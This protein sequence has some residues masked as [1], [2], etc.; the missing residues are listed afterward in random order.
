MKQVCK[1]IA[2]LLCAALLTAF[3]LPV[4]AEEEAPKLPSGKTLEEVDRAL[5]FAAEDDTNVYAGALVGIFQGDEVLYT[6]Y[7]GYSDIAAG[8]PADENA[9]YEWGSISKTFIWVSAMQLWEQGRLDLDADIRTYLPEGFF[10]HLSYDEPIT[11]RNLMNHNAGWQETTRSIWAEDGD[12][13]PSLCEALQAIEPAQVNPPG[14]IVAYSNYGAGVAGYVIECITGQDYCDYVHEH[15]FEPLGMEHTALNPSHSDNAFVCAQRRQMHSYETMQ[16]VDHP[17][18][19]GTNLLYVPAYPAGAAC[20][21]LADLIRYGQAL[22]DDSAPLFAHPGTQQFLFEGTDFYGESDIPMNAHGFWC[23]ERAVRVWG[24]S[25]GTVFGQA[26]LL[27]DP[28]SKT[29]LAVMVN[30][31]GGNSFLSDTPSLV[32]GRL[33]PQT[34]G[35]SPVGTAELDGWYQAARSTPCGML[36]TVSFLETLEASQL[37]DGEL[38]DLG[39]GVLQQRYTPFGATEEVGALLGRRTRRNGTLE[40]LNSPSCDLIPVRS[41]VPQL[42]LFTAFVLA[43]AASVY[44]L[45]IRFKLRHAGKWHP[46]AGAG[47]LTAGRTAR[48]LSF[49]LLMTAL[50]VYLTNHGGIPLAAGAAIGIGQMLCLAVCGITAVTAVLFLGREKRYA[51]LYGLHAGA[52]LLTI[53]AILCFQ[54]YRFWNI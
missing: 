38:E 14:E 16:F 54:M 53:S 4:H 9:C 11:M 1:H 10:R 19:S 52:N 34:Y 12:E 51:L 17:I 20:G 36:R 7:F 50:V 42:C 37:M 32:F 18:D 49:V 27:F 23:E 25:G 29:G 26:N 44:L 48:L 46:Y 8:L 21:T 24:H 28:V 47:A 2:A 31:S 13:I 33:D 41:Y 15:I 43:A 22:V 3:P 5:R 30:D 6:N 39:S 40:V 45:L 35:A